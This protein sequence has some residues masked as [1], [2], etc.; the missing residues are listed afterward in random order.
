MKKRKTQKLSRRINRSG[1]P[2]LYPKRKPA[3]RAKTIYLP[4]YVKPAK[5]KGG[6]SMKLKI[7][8]IVGAALI[9]LTMIFAPVFSEQKRKDF[10]R[11]VW[12]GYEKREIISLLRS[13]NGN[14]E[15]IKNSLD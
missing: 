11:G 13:I 14:L 12:T 7:A 3:R 2:K 5:P 9:I 15:A 6:M 10:Y 1:N 8:L 4:P